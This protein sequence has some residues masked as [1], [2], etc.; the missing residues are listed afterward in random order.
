MIQ[1]IS[2]MAFLIGL[3]SLIFVTPYFF[4][5]GIYT[6][7]YGT[8][9]GLDKLVCAIPIL[10][11]IKSEKLYTG[12]FS[13]VGLS[14]IIFVVSVLVRLLAVFTFTDNFY[15][16]ITTVLFFA[17]S[18]VLSYFMNVLLVYRVLNDAGTVGFIGKM[19]YS[20]SFPIGQYYIGSYLPTTVK[21]F[22]KEEDTFK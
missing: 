8:I 4:S 5:R 18:I 22:K 11:I 12:K 2:A 21:N 9:T 3:F 17:I 6:L 20:L 1:N 10:N 13:K 16:Q 14:T 7:E 15:I 19:L